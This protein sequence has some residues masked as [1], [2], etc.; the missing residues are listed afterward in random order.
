MPSFRERITAFVGGAELRE[1]QVATEKMFSIVTNAYE[2]GKYEL[3]PAELLRQLGEFAGSA[4]LD[5]IMS[6]LPFEGDGLFSADLSKEREH[7]IRRS[8]RA[9]RRSPLYQWSVWSWT[10]WGVGESVQVTPTDENAR[11]AWTEFWDADRNAAI[12]G[13]DRIRAFSEWLLVTGDRYLVHFVSTMDGEDTIRTIPPSQFPGPPIMDPNDNTVPLFYKRKWK[14]GNV[15]KTLYYPDWMAFFNHSERLEQE[16]LLPAGA[17]RAD[18]PAG[19]EEIG[20]DTPG[21]VAVI[22]HVAFNRKDENDLRG[23]PLGTIS[24]AYQDTHQKFMEGRLAV[25]IAKQ[26]FVRRKQ[27]EAGSRGLGSVKSTLQSSYASAPSW[28]DTNPTP[29]PGSN[30]L[31][32]MA[33]KTTDL[34][35]TTGASDAETDNK[36]FSWMA[37]LGDGLFPTSAGLDTSRFATALTMDK[38]QAMLWSGYKSLIAQVFKNMVRIVLLFQEKYGSATHDDKTASVSIDTLSIVDFPPVVTA[39]AEM[40]DT[41]TPQVDADIMPLDV[42]QGIAASAWAILLQALGIENASKFVSQGAFQSSA[43]D[44]ASDEEAAL[45]RQLAELRAQGNAALVLAIE[46]IRDAVQEIKEGAK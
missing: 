14:S 5:F 44:S 22:Q 7:A 29:A 34:P 13:Q 2:M 41:M 19:D 23:W 21:T 25:S 17:K 40:F 39:L 37:L 33:V 43:D 20:D 10:N 46:K 16:G 31:D 28:Q 9:W 18:K 45:E 36:V 8:E 11:D 1:R 35:M 30:E 38:N 12:L 15:D 24:G 26:M 4:D 42:A 27:V 32:N 6:L 3:P